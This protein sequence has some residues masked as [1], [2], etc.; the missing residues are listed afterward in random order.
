MQ[1]YAEQDDGKAVSLTVGEQF[2]VHLAENAST[3]HQWQLIDVDRVLLDVTRDQPIPPDSALPG[4]GGAHAW[5]FLAR[6][7][8]RC[9]LSFVYRRRWEGAAPAQTF[10]LDVTVT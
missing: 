10:S 2:E 5:T 6:A 7:P 3:G 1:T 4:A 9:P 8:G